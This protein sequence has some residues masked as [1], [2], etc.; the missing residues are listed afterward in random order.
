MPS[1]RGL[2]VLAPDPAW[3][4]NPTSKNDFA[5]GYDLGS[6]FPILKG[7]HFIGIIQRLSFELLTHDAVLAVDG[8]CI[9]ATLRAGRT[10]EESGTNREKSETPMLVWRRLP[11][12]Q[13]VSAQLFPALPNTRKAASR[14][15]TPF[16]PT[17]RQSD[18]GIR[19]F[20][21]T[22]DLLRRINIFFKC[23]YGIRLSDRQLAK[24]LQVARGA[25]DRYG[26]SVLQQ[27]LAALLDNQFGLGS[28]TKRGRQAGSP[29]PSIKSTS[30]TRKPA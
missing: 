17:I 8:R 13:G 22:N 3:L 6:T 29:I 26:T 15:V 27:G 28:A 24:S 30:P 11:T 1:R 2:Y 14:R 16:E 18:G 4:E 21:S 9:S 5:N 19:L 10:T 7:T 25:S 20:S 12:H 23:L